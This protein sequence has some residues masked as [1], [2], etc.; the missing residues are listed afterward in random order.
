MD[1]TIELGKKS[2]IN[3]LE[4]LYNDINDYLAKG[5]NYPGWRKDIY[6]VRENAVNGVEANNLYVAKHNRK[7]AGTI[8]LS[9][10]PEPA[11]DEVTW[12]IEADYS[13]IFVIHTFVVHPDYLKRGVGKRLMDFSIEHRIK[14]KAKA[15][16]LDVYENNTPAIHLYEKCGFTYID[17]VDLGYREYGLEWFKLYEKLL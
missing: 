16:R 5:I 11:Y 15:I 10:E 3:E 12:G 1:I 8:I 2:D 7:I 4:Q 13:E 17:K 6:P 14:A 9:H